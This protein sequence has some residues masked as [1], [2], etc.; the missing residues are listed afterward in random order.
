MNVPSA[1]WMASLSGFEPTTVLG[2][3]FKVNNL[4]HLAIDA[5]NDQTLPGAE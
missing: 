4:N 5:L 3:S 2:K 1:S